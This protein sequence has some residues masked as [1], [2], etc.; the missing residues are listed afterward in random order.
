ME[1]SSLYARQRL[2]TVE[3]HVG[4]LLENVSI[5]IPNSLHT[6]AI[7]CTQGNLFF[8]ILIEN[9]NN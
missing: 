9:H 4:S 5:Y 6:T 8:K 3:N 2:V 7:F 1:E